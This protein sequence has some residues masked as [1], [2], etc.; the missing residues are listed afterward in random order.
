MIIDVEPFTVTDVISKE[1]RDGGQYKIVVE[2]KFV[3]LLAYHDGAKILLHQRFN[4][5]QLKEIQGVV[6]RRVTPQRVGGIVQVPE[7]RAETKP[8][9]ATT[10][11]EDFGSR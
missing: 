11:R 2:G 4:P 1:Q 7:P 5:L 10:N 6:M 3:G 9:K 8:E